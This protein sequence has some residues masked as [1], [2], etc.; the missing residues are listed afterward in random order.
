MSERVDFDDAAD[1]A[2]SAAA[3]EANELEHEYLKSLRDEF[4]AQIIQGYVANSN[5]LFPS[6]PDDMK[7][8]A[9]QCYELADALLAERQRR[10]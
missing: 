2:L 1:E 10:G 5:Y 7:A 6:Y 8:A 9:E 4:A 3:Q